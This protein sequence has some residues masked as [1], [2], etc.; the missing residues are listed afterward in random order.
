[1]LDEPPRPERGIVAWSQWASTATDAERVRVEHH[2]GPRGELRA[3]FEEAEDSAQ[4]LDT[5]L[6]AGEVLVAIAEDKVVGHLQLVHTVDA[7]ASEI[8]NLAGW[9]CSS[10]RE[11]A[12]VLPATVGRRGLCTSASRSEPP[13]RSTCSA[14]SWPRPATGCSSRPT[15]P[16]SWGATR[17]SSST[18]TATGSSS[19]SERPGDAWSAAAPL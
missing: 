4:Q 15:A 8:K 6:D 18:P 19:P 5:Y 11:T 9:S 3:L 1:M 7:D 10:G 16:A 13:T 12:K 2:T 14:V 17:A